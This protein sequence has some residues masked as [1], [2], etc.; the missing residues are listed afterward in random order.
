MNVIEFFADDLFSHKDDQ[1]VVS[2]KS[3]GLF[4]KGKNLFSDEESSSWK[5]KPLRPVN[6]NIIPPSLDVPP[7]LS[8][9]C[10]MIW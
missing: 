6:K 8:V 10:K 1:D 3:D 2:N 9:I 5:K 4:G 7:P